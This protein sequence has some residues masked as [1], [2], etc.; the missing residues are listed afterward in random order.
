MLNAPL[1]TISPLLESF[2]LEQIGTR[3]ISIKE[4]RSIRKSIKTLK[5][6]VDSPLRWVF[7]KYQDKEHPVLLK[8]SGEHNLILSGPKALRLAKAKTDKD[9]EYWKKKLMDLLKGDSIEKSLDDILFPGILIKSVEVEDLLLKARGFPAGT[10]RKWSGKEY[11]KMASGK[12][13]RTY[14]EAESRGAK[15]AIRNVQKKIEEAETMDE[16]MEIVKQNA[17]RFRDKDG[18]ML[19]VVKEFIT[20]ARATGAGAKI[21]IPEKE[22]PEEETEL[23]E[24]SEL[25]RMIKDSD[26]AYV[27]EINRALESIREGEGYLK[28]GKTPSGKK[29]NDGQRSSIQ[30]AVDNSKRKIIDA[31]EKKKEEPTT[32]AR[33]TGSGSYDMDMDDAE[34]I[35]DKLNEK[36][37]SG[38]DFYID[39]EDGDINFIAE[40]QREDVTDNIP[41]DPYEIMKTDKP[42]I[43]D[44]LSIESKDIKPEVPKTDYEA[45]EKAK[46]KKNDV[47]PDTE[48]QTGIE[49]QITIEEAN[50]TNRQKKTLEIAGTL[51]EAKTE[52]EVLKEENV[53]DNKPKPFKMDKTITHF[54]GKT[55]TDIY[56]GTIEGYDYTGIDQREVL[57]TSYKSISKAGKDWKSVKPGWMPDIDYNKFQSNKHSLIFDKTEDGK[58]IV[59]IGQKYR[60]HDS[61]DYYGHGDRADNFS[62]EYAVLS[63]GQVAAI[64]DFYRKVSKAEEDRSYQQKVAYYKEKGYS[65]KPKK[66]RI[67]VLS[68]NRMLYDSNYIMSELSGTERNDVWKRYGE[69]QSDL[70]QKTIDMDLMKEEVDNAFSKGQ[71]TSYGDSNTSDALKNEYGVK[72]KRQDGSDISAEDKK[73]L[74]DAMASIQKTFGERNSMNEKFG[75]KLSFAKGTAMHAK[76]AVGLFVPSQKAIGISDGKGLKKKDPLTGIVEKVDYGDENF[77]GFVLSHEYAHMMD[78]YLGSKTGQ[79]YA[80]DDNTGTAGKIAAEFRVNM[81]Q[82]SKSDYINRTCECFARALEQY[83][84]IET[85]GGGAISFFSS[86]VTTG[87][88]VNKEVYETKIKPLCEQFF[89]ENDDLLK[90]ID[91]IW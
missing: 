91:I 20:A 81:N 66:S 14:S 60:Q 82:S 79:W 74:G 1:F 42:G 17:S 69:L 9:L 54:V 88:Y 58:Y 32:E 16:L 41:V 52:E 83:H 87:Q 89:K 19:P 61:V 85:A 6:S 80:S 37:I 4:Y 73:Y 36:D 75:L 63:L 70:K 43:E 71:E 90:S 86:Y 65:G 50:P 22:I 59:P 53:K 67:K 62:Q 77:G 76:K 18:K 21:T 10:I 11:K 30:R 29:M 12:W 35:I 48:P 5:K 57:L 34:E 44:L 72:I 45:E 26:M 51:P 24:T 49:A 31:L 39:G 25:S 40:V 38:V 47:K 13:V 78:Y 46:E 15:Q 28:S 84:A 2:Y 55:Q 8:K 3:K 64:Q 33:Q 27:S 68:S 23:P 56:K 7:I